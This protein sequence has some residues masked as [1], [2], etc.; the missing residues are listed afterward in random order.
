MPR[1][2]AKP[3]SWLLAVAASL[4]AVAVLGVIDYV[5]GSEISFSVFYL[6]PIAALTWAWG[7]G[8][9]LG[10]AVVA[11]TVWG[12][13][14]VSAGSHYSS[15][16]IP[17]WNSLVRL[18]FFAITVWL[19]ADTRKAHAV[20]RA[21]ARQDPLTGVANG[22]AFREELEREV[23]R[24]RRTRSPLTLAYVDLDHF[25]QVNDR[26]G[27]SAGDELLR[28][29]ASRLGA[30]LRSTDV[31]ARL[32]GDEFA[33]LLPDTDVSAA[34]PA[35]ERLAAAVRDWIRQVPGLPPGVGATVGAV[36]FVEA[37]PSADVA[38][39][40]A[41]QRMYEGKRSGRGRLIVSRWPAD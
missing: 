8:S 36:V 10:L 18:A 25:K 31:V 21:L 19:I 3:L 24:M 4:A 15:A 12:F 7:R 2:D 41:D 35:L 27:H 13:V 28:G 17:A 39:H 38:L 6:A 11:A 32:G 29:I 9:G 37:P 22:R 16:L 20:A 14:D 23:A 33:L 26:L 34:S 40:A 5:T 30:G 1:S